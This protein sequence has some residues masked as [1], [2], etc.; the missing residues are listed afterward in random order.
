M[1]KKISTVFTDIGGVLLTNGWDHN[2]RNL[3]VEKF[4]L[5][6]QE[7]NDRHHLIF[8]A[9]ETGKMTLDE[10]LDYLVFYEPRNFLREDFKT[11]MYSC[12]QPLQD[13]LA[14]MKELKEKY[15]LRIVVISNEGRE[16]NQYRINKFKL[17]SFIDCFVSSSFVHLRK[18]D[19]GIFKL[20]ID[21]T[22]APL[23]ECVYIDDRRV[24]VDVAKSLGLNG[25]V[26]TSYEDTKAQLHPLLI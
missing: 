8:D 21:I 26:H 17:N 7:T 4:G 15:R 19:I 3:A 18:P 16:I 14:L 22:Q 1:L 6:M 2:A 25:I 12:S 5:D 23:D 13:M 9:Y 11:F 24:F 10:Y 20:A